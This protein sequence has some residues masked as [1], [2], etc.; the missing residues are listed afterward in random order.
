MTRGE[1]FEIKAPRG[2]RGS[3]QRGRRYGVVVQS[4]LLSGEFART[5]LI[6]PTS[7]SAP[8]G[9]FHP[10]VDFGKGPSLVLTEQTSAHAVERLGAS[11][12]HLSQEEL[13]ELDRALRIVFAL[14]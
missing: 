2:T 10:R 8:D 3:E 11:V 6:A 1:C 14:R 13:I 7:R 5:V 12:G 9:P 4:D